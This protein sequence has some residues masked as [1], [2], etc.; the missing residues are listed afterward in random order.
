VTR[1]EVPFALDEQGRWCA[2]PIGSGHLLACGSTGAG[3]SS[4]P[5]AVIS[6]VAPAPDAQVVGVDLKH[7]ELSQYSRRLSALAVERDE[8]EQALGD[9]VEIMARRKVIA[10]RNGWTRWPSSERHPYLAVVVDELAE[11]TGAEGLPKVAQRTAETC[12][13]HLDRIGRMGRALGRRSRGL[14][15][16][17]GSGGHRRC[18]ASSFAYRFVLASLDLSSYRMALGITD[19]VDLSHLT[20]DLSIQRP[21]CGLW[22]DPTHPTIR[23]ARVAW[24]S[25][26]TV[27]RLMLDHAEMTMPLGQLVEAAATDAEVRV[28]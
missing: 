27:A 23:V 14:H 28:A 20:A 6:Y 24:W 15:T 16:T 10:A 26:V 21:G 3:K 7:V 8:A 13:G 17:C 1:F 22:L 25:D 12:A 5:R 18:V 9:V 4:V 19:G 11:V 2:W